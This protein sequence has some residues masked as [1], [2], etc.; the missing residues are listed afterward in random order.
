MVLIGCAIILVAAAS[1][2]IVLVCLLVEYSFTDGDDRAA[3]RASTLS[4]AVLV[5]MC[6]AAVTGAL[7]VVHV[8]A[9]LVEHAHGRGA[10]D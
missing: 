6:S 10:T 1:T 7:W 3:L 4:D 2:V 9:F 5:C 8:H